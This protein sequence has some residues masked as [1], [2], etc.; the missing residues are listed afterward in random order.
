MPKTSPQGDVGAAILTKPWAAPV[1][2]S[3][4]GA[5]LP[6]LILA[7]GGLFA[8]GDR[9]ERQRREALHGT[10]RSRIPGHPRWDVAPPEISSRSREGSGERP[11]GSLA[12]CARLDDPQGTSPLLRPLHMQ[13]ENHM[14]HDRS[15]SEVTDTATISRTELDEREDKFSVDNERGPHARSVKM[16]KHSVP[17]YASDFEM[18]R[19]AAQLSGLR[20]DDQTRRSSRGE[21]R[22]PAEMQD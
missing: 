12:K 1:P 9:G 15:K 21:P 4:A 10:S 16:I 7:S 17:A 22:I 18:M 20:P 5:G 8:G 11:P 3:I 13:G 2:G 6:G 14:A 19:V